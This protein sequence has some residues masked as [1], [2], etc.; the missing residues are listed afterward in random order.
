MFRGKI[1]LKEIQEREETK[2]KSE[3]SQGNVDPRKGETKDN[4]T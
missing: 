4:R 1:K 3:E 2:K